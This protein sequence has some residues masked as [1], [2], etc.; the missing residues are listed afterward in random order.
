MMIIQ[1]ICPILTIYLS[2]FLVPVQQNSCSCQTDYPGHLL[3]HPQVLFA[4]FFR[5]LL[6][7]KSR[8]YPEDYLGHLAV[9]PQVL[10]FILSGVC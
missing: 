7:K 5:C 10:S 6:N 3:I 2:F 1:D 4:I 8:P 9:H